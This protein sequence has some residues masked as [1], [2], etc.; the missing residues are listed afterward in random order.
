MSAD[1]Q[2]SLAFTT[3]AATEQKT[4]DH[5]DP[6]TKKKRSLGKCDLC[7]GLF[8]KAA[9]TRHLQ[10]CKVPSPAKASAKKPS[11]CFH[12][13]VEGGYRGMYWMHVSVAIDAPLARLDECLRA[14]WLECCGH[15]SAFS[16]NRI[17]YSS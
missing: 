7:G 5:E 8:S 15:L 9:M 10:S 4:S 12:L 6:V 3:E 11:P 17:R 13:V 2:K 16:V 1:R 14:I